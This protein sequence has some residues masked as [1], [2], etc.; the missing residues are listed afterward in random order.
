M[1]I[2]EIMKDLPPEE[3]LK[4]PSDSASQVNYYVY[5]YRKEIVA[6][7]F[8]D[9]FY[10]IAQVNSGDS[11]HG[12]VEAFDLALDRPGLVNTEEVLIKFL[13][14][15]SHKGPMFRGKAVMVARSVAANPHDPSNFSKP[16]KLLVGA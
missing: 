5:G 1:V 3:S 4:L 6:L 11:A 8:A 15:F 2:A 16:S 13:T 9:T 10:W 12:E 14:F 7:A